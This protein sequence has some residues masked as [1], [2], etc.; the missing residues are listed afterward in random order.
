MAAAPCD[1]FHRPS[2]GPTASR[3][4]SQKWTLVTGLGGAPGGPLS[5]LWA[6]LPSPRGS[7][8]IPS[9]GSWF[10]SPWLSISSVHTLPSGILSRHF[11]GER[12]TET[13]G[14]TSVIHQ[15]PE[16]P[17]WSLTRQARSSPVTLEPSKGPQLSLHPRGEP[18]GLSPGL[19]GTW[20]PLRAALPLPCEGG[21]GQSHP[22]PF[23]LWGHRP[24]P[25][26][27]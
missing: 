6:A 27:R 8:Q 12:Q 7:E 22:S 24:S 19:R 16:P 23:E 4:R 26:A 9:S 21:T 18:R 10:P 11:V 3:P 14:R 1:G 17:L 25:R 2:G 13:S 5:C 15:G 20:S